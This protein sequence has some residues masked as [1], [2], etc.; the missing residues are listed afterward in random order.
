MI[1]FAMF[2]TMFT[3]VVGITVH[4][5]KHDKHIHDIYEYGVQFS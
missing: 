4:V 2:F 3:I 1:I 5:D